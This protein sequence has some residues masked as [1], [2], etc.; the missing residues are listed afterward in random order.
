MLIWYKASVITV[1]D[2]VLYNSNFAKRID[3]M[4]SV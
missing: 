2:T 3:P 1:N 4:L